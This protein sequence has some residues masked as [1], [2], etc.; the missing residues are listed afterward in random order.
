MKA[1]K[2]LNVLI[3]I[4]IVILIS[5]ISFGGIYY[6]D[7]NQMINRIPDYILGADLT[8]YRKVS[9]SV[10]NDEDKITSDTTETNTTNETAENTESENEVENTS[11]ENETANET[12]A[13]PVSDD[14][15]RENYRKAAKVIKGRLKSLNVSN[16]TVTCNENTGEIDITLPENDQTDTI[17]SDICEVG[18]F[19]IQDN[20]TSEVLL[21][22]SDVR[23]V[24]VTE[25][26][27]GTVVRRLMT[28]NLTTKG[29]EKYKNITEKYQ[30][31]ANNNTTVTNETNTEENTETNTTTED[32][33]TSTK[34]KQ[35]K[36]AI[37]S[38][39]LL[40]TDFSEIVD[41]GK[42]TLTLS[43]S[44]TSS[45]DEDSLKVEQY[46]TYNIGAIIEND[47]LPI[48]YQVDGN[49]YVA[50]DYNLNDV[51]ILLCIEIIIAGIL[52]TVLIIK[53]KE[54]GILQTIFSVGFIALLLIV[55]RAA[56]VSLSME[57]IIAIGICY[58]VNSMF[59][60][61]LAKELYGK[62]DLTKKE[63]NRLLKKVTQK[64]CLILVPVIII[65]F[66]CAFVNWT[67]IFS[68]GMILFWGMLIS[69]VYNIL[70]NK[71]VS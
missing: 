33:S 47:P 46:S 35:V 3:A 52:A 68:L 10:K 61:M 23:S 5:L 7:K 28:I 56:N 1:Q 50:S 16:Y 41:N 69:I 2:R 27:Y 51:K 11:E 44:S 17:L 62:K 9:L 36:L 67:S 65:T 15:K 26:T 21:D 32:S 18:K 70:I 20:N 34:A 24:N 54:Q 13:E 6:K 58:I 57:G 4:L 45:N 64:Y 19:T 55:I 53:Y 30:N 59:S 12:K 40:T 71:L 37:D 60:F 29:S 8:G 49:K 66:I 31:V 43:Q 38:A 14:T 63:K 42:I 39:T 48:E 22:N 25:N